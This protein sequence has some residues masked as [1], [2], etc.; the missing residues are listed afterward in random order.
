MT[1]PRRRSFLVYTV[2]LLFVIIF[3]FFWFHDFN[4]TCS[5]VNHHSAVLLWLALFTCYSGSA[6]LSHFMK[7]CTLYQCISPSR[8]YYKPTSASSS[9]KNQRLVADLWRVHITCLLAGT[10]RYFIVAVAVSQPRLQ[11]CR[12][13]HSK[14]RVVNTHQWPGARRDK[15]YCLVKLSTRAAE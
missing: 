5:E 8:L 9:G 3:T 2:C 15:D 10:S 13:S 1:T 14:I 6:K 12:C 4:T 11:Y 7:Q